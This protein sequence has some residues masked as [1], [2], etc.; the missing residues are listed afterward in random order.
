MK[1]SIETYQDFVLRLEDI[2]YMFSGI[3]LIFIG[4]LV[5]TALSSI[6]LLVSVIVLFIFV[7][8]AIGVTITLI[9]SSLKKRK[10]SYYFEDECIVR[11]NE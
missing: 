10:D 3:L 6:S 2:I 8:L 1:T 11:E 4:L 9:R 5:A 7:C